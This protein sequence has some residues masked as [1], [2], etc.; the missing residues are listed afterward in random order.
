MNAPI[1]ELTYAQAIQEALATAMEADE[2]VFLMGEDIGVY[3]GAFQVTG[4]LVHR[5][6]EDRV[7]DTPISELGAAGIAVG[8]ALAGSRPILEFQF[9]FWN[10]N[11]RT[12][13]HWPW[14]RS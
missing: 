10:F 3:G 14:S 8:A 4:D 11:S 5:F 7:M 9:Q 6:G 13:P 1:R 12:S 2:R